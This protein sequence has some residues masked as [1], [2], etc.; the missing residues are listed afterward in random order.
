MASRRD[1]IIAL[2]ERIEALID[3][4]QTVIGLNNDPLRRRLRE[5]GRRLSAALETPGDT[6]HR[7][8]YSPLHLATAKIGVDK[9]IFKL[10]AEADDATPTAEEL[11]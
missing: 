11:A 6:A 3:D 10:L 7:V 2:T 4:S 1:E 9:G 8:I 5:A